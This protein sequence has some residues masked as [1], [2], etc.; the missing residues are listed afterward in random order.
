MTVESKMSETYPMNKKMAIGTP[1]M[2]NNAIT[3]T[4]G[5]KIKNKNPTPRDCK[6]LLKAVAADFLIVAEN[7][8]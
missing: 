2:V 5:I 4:I 1:M 6:L 7:K 3:A 8:Y